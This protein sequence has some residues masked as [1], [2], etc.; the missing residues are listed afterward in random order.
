MVFI[1]E[2][3]IFLSS[4]ADQPKSKIT[5]DQ[6]NVAYNE[7]S[8]TNQ[9]YNNDFIRIVHFRAF[10]IIIQFKLP[11]DMG[12]VSRLK[13][14]E[15]RFKKRIEI[16]SIVAYNLLVFGIIYGAY[17]VLDFLTE[18][19]KQFLI[20]LNLILG[21]SAIIGLSGN[22]IPTLKDKFQKLILKVFGYYNK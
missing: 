10:D 20:D 16:F 1:E 7:M 11:R 5:N 15:S 9:S 18:D 8:D 12:E 2:K 13:E 4:L 19:E 17:R 22:F 14:F 21:F 3:H 6:L